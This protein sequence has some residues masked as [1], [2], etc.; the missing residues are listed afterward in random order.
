MTDYSPAPTQPIAQALV[1][2]Q[3][4]VNQLIEGQGFLSIIR[5]TGGAAAGDFTLVL[6]P[7]L[8][9]DVA[10]ESRLA[11]TNITLRGATIGGAALASQVP[12]SVSYPT[13]T[14]VRVV[15]GIVLG[16]IDPFAFEIVVHRAQIMTP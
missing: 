15:F 10:L 7:G 9:G 8:P 5:T 12:I 4:G 16:P 1:T 3:A 2:P 13:L 11:R 6:D 14:T